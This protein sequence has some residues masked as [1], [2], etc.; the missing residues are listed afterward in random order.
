MGHRRAITSTAIVARGRNILSSSLDGTVRLWDVA[1]GEKIH[2]MAAGAGK[3]VPVNSI[4]LGE[5]AAAEFPVNPSAPAPDPREVETD[6]KLLFCAL[7]NGSFEAIDLGAKSSVHTSPTGTALSAITYSAEHNLLAT[8]SAKGVVAIFDTRSLSAPVASF[9]RSEAG[10]ADLVL[11]GDGQSLLISTDDG[12]PFVAHVG[13]EGPR[14]VA[15][16]VG[17]DCDPVRTV[18]VIQRDVWSA[19]DDGVVRSY[20]SAW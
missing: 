18:R 17:T 13:K 6:S 16:L 5:R 3:Y 10:I 20:I 2:I 1:S 12:L 9:M 7:Q 11:A 15:E 19:A 8:G 4:S 14:V